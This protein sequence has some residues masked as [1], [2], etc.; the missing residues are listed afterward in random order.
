MVLI[1]RIAVLAMAAGVGGFSAFEWNQSAAAQSQ[2]TFKGR[3]APVPVDAKTRPDIAGFGSA[4]AVLAGSKLTVNGTFEGFKSPA[5]IAQLHQSKV[6][7]NRGPVV[8][9]LTVTKATSGTIGGSFDLTPAQVE[10]LKKGQFYVQVHTDKA[11][12]GN[13]WGWLLK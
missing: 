11:P 5:T 6:T 1:R 4:T 2:E 3:L 8:F 10:S 13:I 12:D 9:D 7:G